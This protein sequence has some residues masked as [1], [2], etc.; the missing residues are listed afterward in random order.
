MPGHACASLLFPLAEG[1]N[2]PG[3][4]G[5]SLGGGSAAHSPVIRT[6]PYCSVLL[7]TTPYYS[8][9][10]RATPGH[11]GLLRATPGYSG[12]LRATPGYSGLLRATPGYSGLLRVLAPPHSTRRGSPGRAPSGPPP[13][14]APGGEPPPEHTSLGGSIV[15]TTPPAHQLLRSLSSR[16]AGTTTWCPRVWCIPF[17]SRWRQVPT[18]LPTAAA[19]APHGG[20]SPHAGA[21]AAFA[22]V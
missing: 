18:H 11:S 1:P 7:C 3:Y 4:R 19:S 15:P 5:V 13:G 16:L 12:L 14:R 2:G 20:H 8:R 21:V 6:V 10:L 9:L 22:W 17:W